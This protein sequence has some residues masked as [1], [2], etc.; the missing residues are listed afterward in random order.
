MTSR[1]SEALENTGTTFDIADN[2]GRDAPIPI[3]V[4]IYPVEAGRCVSELIAR[5][6]IL[7]C[8]SADF[9]DPQVKKRVKRTVNAFWMSHVN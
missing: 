7:V 1:K 3:L 9:H 6:I 5:L 4:V 8:I 2:V